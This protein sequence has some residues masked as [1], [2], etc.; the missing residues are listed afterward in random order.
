MA[1]TAPDILLASRISLPRSPCVYYVLLRPV[2]K[3]SPVDSIEQARRSILSSQLSHS[4]LLQSVLTSVEIVNE[5]SIYLFRISEK[6]PTAN[7]PLELFGSLDF[8]GLTVHECSSFEPPPASSLLPPLEIRQPLG[9]FYESLTS[10]IIQDIV[11]ASSR[12]F[13]LAQRHVKRFRNGFVMSQVPSL[14]NWEYSTTTRSLLFCQLQVHFSYSPEGAPSHLVIH[15]VLQ[16][17]PFL[18]LYRGLPLPPGAPITLL[19]FGT[20]AYFLANYN[21]P[22]AGLIKQFQTSLL[23]FG[24][25]EWATSSTL[26]PFVIAWIKVENKQ[27]EDKGLTIIYPTRLCLTCLPLASSRALLEYIPELPAPLQPSP[28]AAHANLSSKGPKRPASTPI[29]AHAS[30]PVLVSSPTS[31][32]VFSFRALTLSSKDLGSAANEVGGYVDTVARERERE[33][34]RLKREREHGAVSSSPKATRMTV[35]TPITQPVEPSTPVATSTLPPSQRPVQSFYPSPPQSTPNIVE[36]LDLK[37]SPSISAIPTP[38]LPAVNMTPHES[39]STTMPPAP[40]TPSDTPYNTY[41]LSAPWPQASD[42]YLGMDLD[43][44]D[45]GVE[46]IGLHF[47][48]D[49]GTLDNPP[50]PTSAISFAPNPN[51]VGTNAGMDFDDAF[52]DDDF[53]FFDRPSRIPQFPDPQ[54]QPLSATDSLVSHFLHSTSNAVPS[55]PSNFGDLMGGSHLHIPQPSL[56]QIWSPSA[57]MEGL[58]PRSLVDHTDSLP[59]ELLPSSQGNTP[60]SHS[61]PPTPDIQLDFDHDVDLGQLTVNNSA[62]I[63][64]PIPFASQHTSSD[65][66]YAIG[67]FSHS[68]PP[69][70]TSISLPSSPSAFMAHNEWKLRYDS[71]TNPRLRLVKKLIGVKRK[72]PPPTS[73]DQHPPSKRTFWSS[74]QAHWDEP[75]VDDESVLALNDSESEHE[76]DFCEDESLPASRPVT[77]PPSYIPLGPSL[78]STYFNHKDLLPLSVPLRPPG[79]AISALNLTHPSNPAASVPTPVSP[80]AHLGASTERSRSLEAA[81]SAIA[82]EVIENPVWAESWKANVVGVKNS[83]EIWPTDVRMVKILLEQLPEWQG[84]ADMATIF[85]LNDSFPATFAKNI[86]PNKPL[87]APML[88]IGKGETVVQILPPALRFWEKLGLSPKS[89]QKDINAVVLF[90]D[91]GHNQPLVQ[92]WFDNLMTVYQGKHYGSVTPGVPGMDSPDGIV[93]TRFDSSFRKTFNALLQCLPGPQTASIVFLVLP[94]ALMTLSSSTFRQILTLTKKAQSQDPFSTTLFHFIPEQHIFSE[95]GQSTQYDTTFDLLSASIYN[96]IQIPV[97]RFQS[98]PSPGYDLNKED[99]HAMFVTPSFTLSRPHHN[100]VT[101]VRAPN[102]SLDVIDRYTLLHVGYHLTSCGKWIIACCVD[103]RGENHQIGVWLTQSPVDREGDSGQSDELYA[104]KKIW[105]FAMEFARQTD[106]EWRVVFSRLGVP[107]ERE[108]DAWTT[109]LSHEIAL[110]RDQPPL[111]HTIVCVIP[112]APWF[113]VTPQQNI[114]HNP[115]PQYF[116]N[117]S[118]KH[119]S[120]FSDRSST[121]FAVF[122]RNRL[123]IP[124]PPSQSDLCISHTLIPEPSGKIFS[125]PSP[126]VQSSSTQPDAQSVHDSTYVASPAHSLSILPQ[127]TSVL[128]HCSHDYST[129][130]STAAMTQIH[131][132]GT[133]HSTSYTH[134]AQSL[135][136]STSAVPPDEQL[137]ADITRNFHELAVLSR[138]RWQLDRHGVHKGLPFHLAATDV[139]RTALDMD[140]DRLDSYSTD[141]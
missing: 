30:R 50:P 141:L 135:P 128:T 16:P 132:L 23:G 1:T 110:H 63:F 40:P 41:S 14:S 100:K 105:N 42:N 37:T 123:P 18:D 55:S 58:T 116:K 127:F 118:S 9:H 101:L 91:D 113:Y 115:R 5:P 93:G 8:E 134:S 72:I 51:A 70:E 137:L 109:Y 96:K 33:R 4:N 65:G 90:E 99:V 86:D 52:T 125:L 34:E 44:M 67:K 121:T 56:S 66:K 122:A 106:I 98:H 75:P 102:A 133:Y 32:S 28:Q 53:S 130:T 38:E 39:P 139:I 64:D 138:L 83:G 84:V 24:A 88:S 107:S 12:K 35:T 19:P 119:I 124:I 114:V 15:P 112:D 27:G 69:A 68:S 140:W 87:E 47:D 117:S 89:G 111:H 78:I 71:A 31:D 11:N 97:D 7:F 17:T 6:M 81:A 45:F 48:M 49:I 76:D 10:R 94:M 43:N 21:G 46:D 108:I 3:C 73:H 120:L 103:E 60:E 85:G 77:P 25:G 79:A 20:P 131:L 136:G 54:N 82:S 29:Q 95:I 62:K 57:F 26:S 74:V 2:P 36:T 92:S 61:A 126:A 80:A 13:S 59:P 104:V 129:K 22:T